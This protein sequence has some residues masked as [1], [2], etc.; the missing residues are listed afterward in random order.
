MI[1]NLEFFFFL[2]YI[3]LFS[4]TFLSSIKY[5]QIYNVTSK[6]WINK[7]FSNFRHSLNNVGELRMQRYAPVP[8]LITGGSKF[9]LSLLTVDH[10]FIKF[11]R[12]ENQ[13]TTDRLS[14]INH[15][16]SSIDSLDEI[17]IRLLLRTKYSHS[18][19]PGSKT[20]WNNSRK[21]SKNNS[22]LEREREQRT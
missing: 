1:K 6:L 15:E 3:E 2:F 5:P 10:S 16:K 14:F 21:N 18:K 7:C 22:L 20:C 12:Q 17:L 4:N 13:K 19:Y 8:R 9:I 11:D